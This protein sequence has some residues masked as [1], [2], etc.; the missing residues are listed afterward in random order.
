MVSMS[1]K[2]CNPDDIRDETMRDGYDE[3]AFTQICDSQLPENDP[4]SGLALASGE[5][6]GPSSDHWLPS[7]EPIMYSQE[8]APDRLNG[9][10]SDIKTA[11]EN[12]VSPDATLHD[13]MFE[14]PSRVV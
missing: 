3:N 13:S 11:T 12:H 4:A 5:R 2:E 9:F 14:T 6:S 8:P 10:G 7:T 1:A